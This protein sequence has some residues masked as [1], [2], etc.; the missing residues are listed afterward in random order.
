MVEIFR[1]PSCS[2]GLPAPQP[3]EQSFFYVG[4]GSKYRN[5]NI[6]EDA[7]SKFKDDITKSGL[8]DQVGELKG[9]ILVCDFVP[10]SECHA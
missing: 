2:R 4:R 6:G 8:I 7:I 10:D 3:E 9:K 5:G 1:A